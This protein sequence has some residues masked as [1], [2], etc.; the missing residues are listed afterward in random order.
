MLE[1]DELILIEMVDF[2][3]LAGEWMTYGTVLQKW[4]DS[5]T[6]QQDEKHSFCFFSVKLLPD[7]L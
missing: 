3:V 2:T 5:S 1:E 6:I 7:F 4:T